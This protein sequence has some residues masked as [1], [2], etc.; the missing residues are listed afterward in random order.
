MLPD[1]LGP[2]EAHMGHLDLL[3]LS[4]QDRVIAWQIVKV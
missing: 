2:Y 4:L 1:A 3:T